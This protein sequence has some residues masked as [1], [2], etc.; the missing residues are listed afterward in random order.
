MLEYDLTWRAKGAC[1]GLNPDIFYP[2]SE[3][4]CEQALS[5]CKTC[6]VRIACLNYALESREKQGVWGGASARERR[7]LL[8]TSRRSA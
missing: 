6:E 2:D 1:Q 7:K 4:N 5:I 8:R 3:E